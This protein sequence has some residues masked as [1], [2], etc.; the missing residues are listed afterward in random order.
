M[1]DRPRFR[2][3][4]EQN[5]PQEA[6]L[7]VARKRRFNRSSTALDRAARRAGFEPEHAPGDGRRSVGGASG[8]HAPC[9][10]LRG[11]PCGPRPHERPPV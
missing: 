7:G 6:R 1:H 8:A 3:I 2:R 11:A 4:A 9:F 5:T 10:T